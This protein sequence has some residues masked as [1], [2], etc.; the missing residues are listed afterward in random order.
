MKYF[1]LGIF[2]YVGNANAQIQ[3]APQPP[4]SF[5][6][7]AGC[8]FSFRDPDTNIVSLHPFNIDQTRYASTDGPCR[9]DV[10]QACIGP[11]EGPCNGSSPNQ[12]G[13]RL[14]SAITCNRVGRV[15]APL[16]PLPVKWFCYSW[17]GILFADPA[18]DSG[19]NGY[20]WF[21]GTDRHE[22]H[23]SRQAALDSIQTRCS[24]FRSPDRPAGVLVGP[25]C[26]QAERA[27]ILRSA[28]NQVFTPAQLEGRSGEVH[29]MWHCSDNGAGATFD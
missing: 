6:C 25:V 5:Q 13:C 21:M 7:T 3:P 8:T 24:Q 12:F 10:R 4:P 14:T 19:R 27:R 22:N 28:N 16:P 18:Q 26:E 11:R 20:C 9:A 23:Q 15:Q 2:V 29:S 17:C 1:F